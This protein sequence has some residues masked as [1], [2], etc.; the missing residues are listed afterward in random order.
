MAKLTYIEW[1]TSVQATLGESRVMEY[2]DVPR[3]IWAARFM[4]GMR[5]GKAAAIAI[6]EFLESLKFKHV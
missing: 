6:D 3:H 1:K 4:A 5:P 2:T